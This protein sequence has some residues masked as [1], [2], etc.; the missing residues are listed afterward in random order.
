MVE[1]YFL[2]RLLRVGGVVAFDDADRRSVN[3]VLRHALTYPSYQVYATNATKPI[4][5]TVAGR[6]RQLL[7]RVPHI[8]AMIRQD[9]LRRDWDIGLFGSCVAL[10]K[11][12]EDHRTSGWDR[13][14]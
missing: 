3:R 11:I 12:A 2:N 7:S 5:I 9:V 14:F 6:V 8:D 4:S 10:E 13:E 1:F